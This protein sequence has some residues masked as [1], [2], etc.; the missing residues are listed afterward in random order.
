MKCNMTNEKTNT[1]RHIFKLHHPGCFCRTVLCSRQG[2]RVAWGVSGMKCNMTIEKT[3]G[4]I[5]YKLHRREYAHR[6][7]F[8]VNCNVK[9][10]IPCRREHAPH[11]R[12]RPRSQCVKFTNIARSTWTH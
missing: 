9:T 2:Q 10:D 4:D 11:T 7:I 6:R 8:A 1:R 12:S 5:I 3:Q